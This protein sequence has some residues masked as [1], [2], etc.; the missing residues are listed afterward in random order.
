[1]RIEYV[2]GTPM[3]QVPSP[4]PPPPQPLNG[5]STAGPTLIWYAAV[6]VPPPVALDVA[7]D[8]AVMV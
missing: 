8:E 3:P 6:T 5:T 4:H 2:V 7:A 1:M